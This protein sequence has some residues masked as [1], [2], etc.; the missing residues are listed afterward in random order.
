M[1]LN[2]VQY[3]QIIAYLG[4]IDHRKMSFLFFPLTLSQYTGQDRAVHP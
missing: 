2:Y 4:S 1:D 3:T